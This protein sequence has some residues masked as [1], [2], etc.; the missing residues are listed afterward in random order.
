MGRKASDGK[1]QYRTVPGGSA[2]VDNELY[3][4]DGWNGLSIGSVATGDTDRTIE[5]EADVNAVYEFHVP[6]GVNPAAGDFL[7]WNDPTTFQY[8]LSHLR[9]T[10]IGLGEAPAVF[11]T[12]AR[13][14]DVDGA[15][16]IQGR[17]L[18]GVTGVGSLS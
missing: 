9:T 2:V 8:G 11:V 3:R 15:Y 7:Y 4:I 18:N 16:V 10:P 17:I 5:F 13:V 12:K 14:A 6:S 1:S